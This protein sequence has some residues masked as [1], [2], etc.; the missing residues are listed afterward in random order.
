[1]FNFYSAFSHFFVLRF[2]LLRQAAPFWLLIRNLQRETL[3]GIPEPFKAQIQSNLKIG[4][5][6]LV[7]RKF[8]FEQRIIMSL[9]FIRLADVQNMP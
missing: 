2:L 6:I 5:P 3:V 8:H 1:M 9:S 4:E 7:R